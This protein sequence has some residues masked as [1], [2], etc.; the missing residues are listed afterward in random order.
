MALG[1]KPNQ[2]K[3][4][5]ASIQNGSINIKKISEKAKIARPHVYQILTELEELGLIELSLEKPIL[6]TPVGIQDAISTLVNNKKNE[7]KNITKNAQKLLQHYEK[8]QNNDFNAI[9]KS[10]FVWISKEKPYLRKRK[11]E[12]ESAKKSIKIIT[13]WHRFPLNMYNYAE[14]V[15][16]ALEKNVRI[17]FILEKPP[18]D[19]SLPSVMNDLMKYSNFQIRQTNEPPH[20][21]VAIFDKKTS[22]IDT[23]SEVGLAKSPALWTDNPCL[24]SVLLDYFEI[25]WKNSKKVDTKFEKAIEP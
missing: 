12:I 1:L 17:K 21:I 6:I 20:A 3:V 15:K 8:Y 23:N 2:S 4:Y 22:I 18:T 7:I 25:L 9:T 11:E 14:T 5:L 16:K 10:V 19:Y 24:I 13:S